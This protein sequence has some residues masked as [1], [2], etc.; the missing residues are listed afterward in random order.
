MKTI[1]LA[2]PVLLVSLEGILSQDHDSKS[3]DRN[4]ISS[5]LGDNFPLT[6][7]VT[8][9]SSNQTEQ[10]GPFGRYFHFRGRGFGRS[11]NSSRSISRGG[12]SEGSDEE[13]RTRQ[14]FGRLGSNTVGQLSKNRVKEQKVDR[15]KR[16]ADD[17]DDM[18]SKKKSSSPS[19]SIDDVIDSLMK[20]L[21]DT[22]DDDSKT[23]KERKNP[24]SA[25]SDDLMSIMDAMTRMITEKMDE[26]R[27]TLSKRQRGMSR[28][29]RRNLDED[30]EHESLRDRLSYRRMSRR[31]PSSENKEK[32]LETEKEGSDSDKPTKKTKRHYDEADYFDGNFGDY[33][34]HGGSH[35]G[36]QW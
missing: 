36:G 14:L 8:R 28:T 2:F 34:G 23:D 22:M 15:T 26:T 30:H 5:I 4:A 9:H 31:C 17:D 19:A 16:Q 18:K 32:K 10:N 1:L 20:N 11:R 13:S 7:L 35:H 33:G 24:I 25:A 6:Y 29:L 27:K 12:N 3:D 21:Q